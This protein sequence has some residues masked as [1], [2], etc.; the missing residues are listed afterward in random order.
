MLFVCTVN[1]RA[2]HVEQGG[3]GTEKEGGGA[4]RMKVRKSP[5]YRQGK[6]DRERIFRIVM[7]LVFAFTIL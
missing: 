3:K 2:A 1:K 6:R 5:K 4:Q 7:D